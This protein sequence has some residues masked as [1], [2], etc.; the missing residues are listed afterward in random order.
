MRNI[1]AAIAKA[2]KG[3][4]S[5][6]GKTLGVF[7]E[8]LVMPCFHCMDAA[9]QW[10]W[11]TIARPFAGG[12]GGGKTEQQATLDA[13]AEAQQAY[14]RTPEEE[15]AKEAMLQI[16]RLARVVARGLEPRKDVFGHLVESNIHNYIRSLTPE[17]REIMG[18]QTTG[19]IGGIING[20]GSVPGLPLMNRHLDY[21]KIV[22]AKSGPAEPCVDLAVV[23]PTEGP[24]FNRIRSKLAH[25]AEDIAEVYDREKHGPLDGVKVA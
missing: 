13:R 22:A 7:G 4:A 24:M 1:M 23:G 11:G 21:A 2:L 15:D 14:R 25:R 18:K 12:R 17:Q 16:R 20:L 6:F 10:G 3:M 8:Y 9:I 19:T 5:I